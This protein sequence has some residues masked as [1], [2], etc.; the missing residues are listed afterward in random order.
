MN[1]GVSSVERSSAT[2]IGYPAVRGSRPP[3]VVEVTCPMS[4]VGAIWPPVIP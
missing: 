1:A 4:D 2:R 3:G